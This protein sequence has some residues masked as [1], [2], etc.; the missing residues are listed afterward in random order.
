MKSK[1]IILFLFTFILCFH[2]FQIEAN[3]QNNDSTIESSSQIISEQNDSAQIDLLKDENIKNVTGTFFWSLLINI[4][5]LIFIIAFVYYPNNKQM[6]NIFSFFMFN[7][8]IFLLT[9]LLNKIKISMGA[10]FGLF[11][12]FSMLRYRTE[13]ISM[14]DMTYLFI[15]ISVGLIS[16]IHLKYYELIIINGII[17]L[18][19]YILDGNKFFRREQSKLVDYE[20]IE[21]IKAGNYNILLNDLKN[22]TGLT[23]HRINIEKID[24]LK[25]SALIKIFF[26]EDLR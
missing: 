9:F 12:V 21:M 15:F 24:F 2:S 3:N 19:I 4:I 22:R 25:D 26:Y 16:A 23:I 6:E 8:M 18:F 17:L 14:K 5:T 11:A 7:L 20:N 10:A 13:G 1:L